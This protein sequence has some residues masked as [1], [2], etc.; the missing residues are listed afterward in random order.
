MRRTKGCVTAILGLGIAGIVSCSLLI[1]FVFVFPLPVRN[2]LILGLDS[3]GPEGAVARSDAILVVG[4]PQ[5]TA[6]LGLLSI[7][8]DLFIPAPGFGLQR[9]NVIHVL[10]GARG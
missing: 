6:Q 5:G 10:G 8:R 7:P 9:V 4:M 3:R 2:V 1:V